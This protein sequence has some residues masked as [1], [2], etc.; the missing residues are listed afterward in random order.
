MR[1]HRKKS[2][3]DHKLR[4]PDR[5]GLTVAFWSLSTDI[6]KKSSCDSESSEWNLENS[7]AR[8]VGV[9]LTVGSNDVASRW[10]SVAAR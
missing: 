10:G 4:L 3:N 8:D 2:V 9:T 7:N 5:G 1:D 6:R